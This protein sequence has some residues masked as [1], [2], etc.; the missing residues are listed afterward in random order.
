ME[1]TKDVAPE[2]TAYLVA[3]TIHEMVRRIVVGFSPHRIILFGSHARGSAGPDS[4]IDLLIVMPVTGSRR[5]LTLDIRKTLAGIGIAKDVI[6][7]SP[8]EVARYRDLVGTIIHPAVR[9][10][11]V[12]YERVA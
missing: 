2:A 6:V 3:E 9:E 1:N 11:K 4:D 7:A 12:L 8:E 10:G 5:Q